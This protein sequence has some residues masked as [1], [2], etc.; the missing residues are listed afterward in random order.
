MPVTSLGLYAQLPSV[1][2]RNEGVDNELSLIVKTGKS[3]GSTRAGKELNTVFS[4]AFRASMR[5]GYHYR[6]G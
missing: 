4:C 2:V 3:E 6:R 5:S 1:W